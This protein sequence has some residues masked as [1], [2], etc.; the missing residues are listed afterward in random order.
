MMHKI[1]FKMFVLGS[2][3]ECMIGVNSKLPFCITNWGLDKFCK[4]QR[5]LF[6]MF[7]WDL[8]WLVVMLI[9]YVFT[10]RKI[11]SL[12]ILM[13]WIKGDLIVTWTPKGLS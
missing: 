5:L 3:K 4:S 9:S 12:V 13:M 1:C 2:L 8:I 6:K 7:E 11:R 10:Y